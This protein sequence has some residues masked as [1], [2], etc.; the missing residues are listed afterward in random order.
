M[1]G[2]EKRGFINPK[3][4]SLT[5]EK[6]RELTGKNYTDDEAREIVS[7]IK[8]LSSILVQQMLKK[9]AKAKATQTYRFSGEVVVYQMTN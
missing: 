6:L 2:N 9:D 8:A 3:K 1:Y 7:N 5:I 4:E